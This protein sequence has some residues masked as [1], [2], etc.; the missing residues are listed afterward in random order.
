MIPLLQAT[1]PRD[2]A[3]E[4]RPEQPVVPKD[5][6]LPGEIDAKGNYS[7]GVLIFLAVA[8]IAAAVAT[9]YFIRRSKPPKWQ[10]LPPPETDVD[11]FERLCDANRLNRRER[12][13]MQAAVRRRDGREALGLFI[14]PV[15]FDALLSESSTDDRTILNEVRRKL[16]SSSSS[17]ANR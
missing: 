2:P 6:T 4:G 14:D 3:E 5:R 7:T 11:A 10:S 17:E 1:K 16:F 8:I 13:V 12:E 9:A 15:A